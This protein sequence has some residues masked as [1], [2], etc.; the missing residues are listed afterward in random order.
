MNTKSSKILTPIAE[1]IAARLIDDVSCNLANCLNNAV[2]HIVPQ[3]IPPF[4]TFH[5][6]ALDFGRI[7]G[8]L[9]NVNTSPY[10]HGFF[11]DETVVLDTIQLSDTA[12]FGKLNVVLTADFKKNKHVCFSIH[13]LDEHETK[14]PYSSLVYCHTYKRHYHPSTSIGSR[15]VTEWILSQNAHKKGT[16][17]VRR[18]LVT[19]IK[20]YLMALA[21]EK[22]GKP[23]DA[24]EYYYIRGPNVYTASRESEIIDT[25]SKKVPNAKVGDVLHSTSVFSS[26]P[27][28]FVKG[29]GDS[30]SVLFCGKKVT[31]T[32][33]TYRKDKLNSSALIRFI[34]HS[35]LDR[36]VD[37]VIGSVGALQQ[38]STF[39]PKYK[40]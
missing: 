14:D 35:I 20:N 13:I 19:L 6:Y 40:F 16:T 39:K 37:V 24:F 7:K 22:N 25:F 4:G 3:V 21:Q 33:I 12:T 5:T 9:P 32:Y 29:S 26:L 36:I 10:N 18:T 2:P 17:V 23:L 1:K 27:V 15:K 28:D 30:I 34:S 8:A 31:N 38:K 11:A